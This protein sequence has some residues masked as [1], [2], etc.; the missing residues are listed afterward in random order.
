MKVTRKIN[1]RIITVKKFSA[2]MM[3]AI[4]S[5][6]LSGFAQEN[7]DSIRIDLNRAIE[8]ALSENPTMRISGRDIEVKKNYKREQIVALFPDISASGSY[9]HTIQKQKMAIDMMGTPMEMEVGTANSW[10]A[11]FSASLP[12]VVPALWY[13]VKLSQLDVELALENARSSRISLI[14]EV[15]KAYYN[16]L[17]AQNSYEVLLLNYNN[18]QMNFDNINQKY[19]Q[20]LASEFDKLRAEVQVKNQIPNIKSA[21]NALELSIMMLKVLIGVDIR[22]PF[23]FEGRLEDF[24][25]EMLSKPIPS[26]DNLSLVN[27]PDL[28]QLEISLKQLNTAQKLT[29]SSAAPNLALSGGWQIGS[30]SDNLKFKEYNWFPYSYVAVGLTIP[31]VSW[32]GT[33]YKIKSNKLNIQSLEDQKQYL[34]ETMKLNVRNSINQITTAIEEL[35][36]NK[37][38]VIQAEKAYSIAQKQYEIG[39]STWLDLSSAELALT[40]SR[41]AYN[42]S[43]Y[44]YLAAYADLEKIL[45]NN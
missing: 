6:P 40:S 3:M 23:V 17:L 18:V 33:A 44:N 28:A 37:E 24:E 7:Q 9:N 20:G 11:G 29:I 36:S 26:I 22:E 1:R 13:N 35:T 30:M 5:I 38:T 15:K 43:I 8:I 19:E 27:N 12:V 14:N 42:Q 10:N 16:Y 34:E 31:I 25:A 4:L 21:E 39:M 45:G 32:A 2:I 41:L